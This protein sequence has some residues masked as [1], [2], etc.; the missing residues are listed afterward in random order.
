MVR[1]G[2]GLLIG[3]LRSLLQ[4]L[5]CW[6]TSNRV[7]RQW[8]PLHGRFCLSRSR[9]VVSGSVLHAIGDEWLDLLGPLF[10]GSGVVVR[11]LDS[12]LAGILAPVAQ[13][14]PNVVLSAT[15][16]DNL[17]QVDPRLTNDLGLLIVVEQRHLQLVVV[18]GVVHGKSQLLVPASS[19][20]AQWSLRPITG[21]LL[22]SV[23][24]PSRGLPSSAVGIGLLGLFAQPGRAVRVLLPNGFPIGEVLGAI[25]DHDQRADFRA[26]HGHI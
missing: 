1:H 23:S 4:R 17:L 6:G 26:V 21:A 2:S 24:L 22:V 15:G 19:L 9:Q 16:D 3:S 25:N 12:D 10:L 13:V 5:R 14:V 8:P 11:D 7:G 20:S 18:R